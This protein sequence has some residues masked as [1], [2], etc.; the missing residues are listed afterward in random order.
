MATPTHASVESDE[1]AYPV[2]KHAHQG[3]SATIAEASDLARTPIDP[4]EEKALL[5]RLDTFVAPVVGLLYFTAFLDRSNIGNAATDG[6]ITDIGGPANGLNLASS[7]FYV[8]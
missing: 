1:K 8:T 5:R 4:A 7:L 2:E 6:L 3:V